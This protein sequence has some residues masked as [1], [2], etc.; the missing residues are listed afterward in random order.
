MARSLGRFGYQYQYENPADQKIYERDYKVRD[1]YQTKPIP[2]P[3][4][5]LSL[6]FFT[7]VD[8]GALIDE[9]N[10]L[11]N[12]W[13]LNLTGSWSS[14]SYFTWT[15]TSGG[16]L[17]GVQYNVQYRDTWGLNMRL[18][19]NLKFGPANVQLFV[20]VQNLLNIKNFS[21]YGF[22]DG[23]DYENYMR[24]LHLEDG[25]VDSRFGYINIPGSD[26]PGDVRKDGT[27]YTPIVAVGN[28]SA[29]SNIV[30]SAIYYDASQKK[31]MEYKNNAWSEVESARV[32]KILD[33]K[34]YIDMPNM[35]YFVFLNPRDIFWGIKLSFEF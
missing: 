30:S 19:K 32:N 35:D 34:S 2:A 1:L 4:A 5:R 15:G 31:Y 7:P 13:R 25:I 12:D 8:Y 17:I 18:S 16:S 6:D 9:H 23:T 21:G 22:T 20:D 26:K 24:S 14:G 28:L 10:G 3:Y 33:D 27:S 29:V 11:L